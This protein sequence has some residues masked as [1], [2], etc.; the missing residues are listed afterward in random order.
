MADEK[1]AAA[2][3]IEYSIACGMKE[4][5]LAQLKQRQREALSAFLSGHDVMVNL[6]TGYGKSAVYQLAPFCYDIFHNRTKSVALVISPLVALM[7]D[8]VQVLY[9]KNIEA[10]YLSEVGVSGLRDRLKN[11]NLRV[12]F[13]SPESVLEN[14]SVRELFQN[15]CYR[16]LIC[17]VFIDEA[18]CVA[19][20][21]LGDK[22]VFRIWYGRL[23][24]LRSL[25]P[26][27]IHMVALTATATSSIQKIIIE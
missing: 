14:Q 17:D 7:K 1:L 21:G 22:K 11:G 15:R 23:S 5:S 18:H 2:E 3:K 25:L 13:A 12:V 16:E 4:L 20:W 9:G 26:K 24:E 27:D 6:P 19:K 10:V 8:Q